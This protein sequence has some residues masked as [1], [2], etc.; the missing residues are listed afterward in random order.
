MYTVFQKKRHPF[1]FCKNLAKH[2]PISIIFGSSIPEEICNKSM[3]LYPPHLFTVLIPYLVK[4]MI[5]LPVFTC[6]KKWPCY[7]VQQV[8]QM[9]SE[10]DNFSR[11]MPEEFCN[12]AS[13]SLSPPNLVLHVATVPCKASNNL[14]ACQILHL[15]PANMYV[16]RRWM[17]HHKQTDLVGEGSKLI[18]GK[19]TRCDRLPHRDP[20]KQSQS[21]QVQQDHAGVETTI[22]TSSHTHTQFLAHPFTMSRKK[23]RGHQCFFITKNSNACLLAL[24]KFDHSVFGSHWWR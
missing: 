23:K 17:D 13:M 19:F 11:Y 3:H 8:S 10:C 9:P 2:Y 12:E 24:L 15:K 4:I 6:F 18:V 22:L 14:M 21:S 20:V 5:Q 7:C 1:Y 16:E